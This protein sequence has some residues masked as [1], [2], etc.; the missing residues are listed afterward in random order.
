VLTGTKNA[1]VPKGVKVTF[2]ENF[3]AYEAG[4]TDVRLFIPELKYNLLKTKF[5]IYYCL[6]F[7]SI[8]AI[9][10]FRDL[11]PGKTVF[12]FHSVPEPYRNKIIGYFNDFPLELAYAR[13]SIKNFHPDAVISVGKFMHKWSLILGVPKNKLYNIDNFTEVKDIIINQSKKNELRKK[14]NLPVNKFIYILTLRFLKKK[15]ILEFI[16]AIPLSNKNIF[17]IVCGSIKNGSIDIKNEV[18]NY[19]KKENLEDR[20]VFFFDKFNFSNIDSLYKA[21]DGFVLPSYAEGQP[22]SILEAFAAKLP[23]IAA[24]NEGSETLIKHKENGWFVKAR[25]SK[26]LAKMLNYVYKL[27]VNERKVITNRA[28]NFVKNRHEISHQVKKIEKILKKLLKR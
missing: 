7:S 10:Y 18:E 21:S 14:F 17:Y 22:V 26:N 2:L 6:N 24:K 16:H 12:T 5:D 11:L 1:L 3:K 15:G 25:D 9:N 8:T 27:E 20:V 28:Y 23:V 13:N 19:I 4:K